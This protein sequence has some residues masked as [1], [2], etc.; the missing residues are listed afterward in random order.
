MFH[1]PGTPAFYPLLPHATSSRF[2]S[3]LSFITS[4]SIS[5]LLQPFILYYLM[6]RPPGTLAFYLLLPHDPSH[7]YSSLLSFITSCSIPQVFQPYPLS[8]HAPFLQVLQPF[9]FYYLMLDPPGTPAF[10]P[11]LPHAPSP[12]YSSLISFSPSCSISQVLRPLIL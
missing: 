1:P 6:H 12:R 3:L 4:C 5:Q 7:R 8:P 9:I 11:L 2:S 10:Y